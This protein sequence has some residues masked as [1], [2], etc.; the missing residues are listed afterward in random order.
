MSLDFFLFFKKKPTNKEPLTIH[1]VLSCSQPGSHA[2]TVLPIRTSGHPKSMRA[3]HCYLTLALE[4]EGNERKKEKKPPLGNLKSKNWNTDFNLPVPK[5]DPHSRGCPVTTLQVAMP[6][7][8]VNSAQA[9]GK[10]KLLHWLGL[11]KQKP[12]SKL[13]QEQQQT[14]LQIGAG[15]SPNQRRLFLKSLKIR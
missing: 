2:K 12:A 13:I 6:S 9:Y 15:M 10:H 8:Q 14:H 4:R 1:T 5:Q 11:A 7:W 3:R